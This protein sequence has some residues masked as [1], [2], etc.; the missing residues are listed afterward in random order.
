[1]G[2]KKDCGHDSKGSI[3]EGVEGFDDKLV[4]ARGRKMLRRLKILLA[5]SSGSLIAIS[6]FAGN[7]W[8]GVGSF[9]LCNIGL[10]LTDAADNALSLAIETED[11]RREESENYRRL[12]DEICL[13]KRKGENGNG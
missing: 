12:S 7:V 1:M 2:S 8:L 11:V 9:V 5:M 4:F 3:L 13:R 10:Y 6:W